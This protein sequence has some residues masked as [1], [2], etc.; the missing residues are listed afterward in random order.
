MPKLIKYTNI[1]SKFQRTLKPV[2]QKEP[3]Y[4]S[5]IAKKLQ[6]ERE[7]C[8]KQNTILYN[9]F[10][11]M[12]DDGTRIPRQ[13]LKKKWNKKGIETKRTFR[14][15]EFLGSIEIKNPKYF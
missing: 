8:D 13:L 7:V 11:N 2:V 10:M 3:R 9:T 5:P 12:T 1:S 4:V 6:K 14:W 15:R